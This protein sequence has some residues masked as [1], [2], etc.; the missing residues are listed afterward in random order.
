MANLHIT[1]QAA[2]QRQLDAA[3]R[4]LF[5]EEDPLAVHTVVAA[6]R[7]I[8]VDLDEKHRKPSVMD[9]VYLHALPQ[10]Q[11]RF[12]GRWNFQDLKK[13]HQDGTSKPANF[14]K[15]AD[16]DA[17]KAL[18]SATLKTDHLLLEACVLYV[19][20]GFELTPEMSAFSR[21]HLAV[22]PHEQ[23]DG[24]KTAAGFVHTLERNAQL[25]FGAFLL[26]VEKPLDN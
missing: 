5:A 24:I 11:D 13:W 2:A 3:I 19:S 18:N 4:I 1:K 17:D 9:D 12:P 10:L 6:A 26:S 7:R 25:Q 21:W 22:Y 23:D 16:R 8:L 20:L 14:L 15:H